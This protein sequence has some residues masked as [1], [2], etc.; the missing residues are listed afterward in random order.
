MLVYPGM[1]RL[2]ETLTTIRVI[3]SIK[4]VDTGI[5]LINNGLGYIHRLPQCR[6]ILYFE[7][8]GSRSVVA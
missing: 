2:Y 7:C 8:R 3:A 5:Q 6:S 4:L 1:A